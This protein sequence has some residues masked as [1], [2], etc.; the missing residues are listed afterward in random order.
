MKVENKQSFQFILERVLNDFEHRELKNRPILIVGE[1]GTGKTAMQKLVGKILTEK[2]GQEVKVMFFD[3]HA[4]DPTDLIGNPYILDGETLHAVPKEMPIKGKKGFTIV[5]IDEITRV[6]PDMQAPLYNL[7]SLRK[8]GEHELSDDCIIVAMCNPTESETEDASY[9]TLEMDAAM[10][11]RFRVYGMA[12]DPDGTLDYFLNTYGSD[13]VVYQWLVSNPGLINY[14]GGKGTPRDMESLAK[15]ILSEGDVDT[16]ERSKLRGII[17]AD[18]GPAL[19]AEFFN[20]LEIRNICTADDILFGDPQE[21][22]AKLDRAKERSNQFNIETSIMRAV[23]DKYLRADKKP[24]VE[25]VIRFLE[26]LGPERACAVTNMIIDKVFNK[27]NV[28]NKSWS[29]RMHELANKAK[30]LNS[31]I[32]DWMKQIQE[33]K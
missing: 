19:A 28:A 32:R 1:T 17:N 11:N 5:V 4:M 7:I 21:W 29:K 24:N 23:A 6:M 3:L 33:A 30:E 8:I 14:K 16:M 22:K 20:Y 12:A 18:I 27:K 2:Y 26:G 10:L 9:S 25:N 15:S 13:N 31:P